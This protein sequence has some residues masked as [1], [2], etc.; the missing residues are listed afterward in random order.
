ME[1]RVAVGV[2]VGVFAVLALQQPLKII[3]SAADVAGF[4]QRVIQIFVGD[5]L[6]HLDCSVAFEYFGVRGAAVGAFCCEFAALH[7]T[8]EAEIVAA[9]QFAYG[10]GGSIF[11][12]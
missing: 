5:H 1:T 6:L 7:Y 9:A 3:V 12:V 2:A 4:V 11:E 10:F 8:G